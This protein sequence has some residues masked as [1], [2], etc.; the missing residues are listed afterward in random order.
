MKGKYFPGNLEKIIEWGFTLSV[1]K[2]V[3]TVT[4]EKVFDLPLIFR[5]S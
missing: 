2:W 1:R 5:K 4:W 3:S